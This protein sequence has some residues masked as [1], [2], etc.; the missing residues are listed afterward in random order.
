MREREEKR[1][2]KLGVGGMGSS[3]L[4][5]PVGLAQVSRPLRRRHVSASRFQVIFLNF[6]RSFSF[7][8]ANFYG[9]ER[10]DLLADL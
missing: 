8:G 3:H 9:R 6:G 7:F 2:Y 5:Y 1:L 10:W 4:S